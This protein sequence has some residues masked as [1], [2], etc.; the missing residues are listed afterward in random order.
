M[1]YE[2]VNNF[3][4]LPKSWMAR[5]MR[6]QFE[7][8]DR[9]TTYSTLEV[10]LY[11]ETFGISRQKID[12]IHWA[13][14]PPN[15]L[16]TEAFVGGSTSRPLVERGGTTPHFSKQPGACPIAVSWLSPGNITC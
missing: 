6:K 12:M 10:D 3:T 9:F 1:F 4:E 16:E 15:P 7:K 8:I 5:L 2:N 14:N 11:A 13:V